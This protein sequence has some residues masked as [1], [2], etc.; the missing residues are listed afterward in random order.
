MA[1]RTDKR[2]YQ[3]RS[4]II[5]KYVVQLRVHLFIL[6][7]LP[8]KVFVSAEDSFIFMLKPRKH[9]HL[10]SLDSLLSALGELLQLS[11][12]VLTDV[13]LLILGFL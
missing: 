9:L 5:V 8:E 13:E 3:M 1:D 10:Q 6:L 2:W 12:V 4:V 11:S 7:L